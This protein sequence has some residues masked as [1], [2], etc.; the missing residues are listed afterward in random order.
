[1]GEK[2]SFVE[3]NSSFNEL[4]VLGYGLSKPSSTA[5]GRKIPKALYN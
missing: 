1:L 2:A 4:E 5:S 3:A